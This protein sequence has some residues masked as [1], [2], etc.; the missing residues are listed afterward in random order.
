MADNLRTDGPSDHL[1]WA[2]LACHDKA[3]TPYPTEWR[4]DR[5]PRIAQAFESVRSEYG[6]PINIGSGYRTPAH[7]RAVGGARF[8]QH[9]EGRALDLRPIPNTQAQRSRLLEAVERVVV[10]EPGLIMGVAPYP[11]FVHIDTR[12]GLRVARWNGK[13]AAADATRKA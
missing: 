12:P 1:S 2:E 9:V 3:R 11:N 4:K 5:A 13:R 6:G 10:N 8:S 7:N